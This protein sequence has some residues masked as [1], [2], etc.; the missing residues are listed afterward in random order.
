MNMIALKTSELIA[1]A[2]NSDAGALTE[3]KRRHDKRV[4]AGKKPIAQ[5]AEY[6]GVP[7][8]AKKSKAK[9]KAKAKPDLA[10]AELVAQ[11]ETKSAGQLKYMLTRAKDPVKVAAIS[12]VY[13]RKCNSA[14]ASPAITAIMDA[15]EHL[16]ANEL[17]SI[18][19]ALGA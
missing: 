14:P 11:Y 17:A 7:M 10:P 18:R 2:S 6:L 15:I 3:L 19:K 8:P 5:V 16:G 13:N 9:S 12:E 4:K 1:L